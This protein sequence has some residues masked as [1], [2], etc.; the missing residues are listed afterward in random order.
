V[1]AAKWCGCP[2]GTAAEQAQRCGDEQG[3][4]D[5]GIDEHAGGRGES[6]FLADHDLRGDERAEGDG[7][8]QCGGGDDPSGSLEPDRNGFGVRTT[9][10]AGFFDAREEEDAVVGGEAKDGC[11]QEQELGCLEAALARV[12]EETLE[13]AVL[14]DEHEDAEHCAQAK[15]IHDDLQEREDERAAQ[16]EEERDRE[17]GD[18]AERER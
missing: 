3:A 2:P 17:R 5:R 18:D 10:V 6:E 8:E 12:T 9:C 13:P 11:E 16:R 7:E 4:D 1:E 15:G 14:E